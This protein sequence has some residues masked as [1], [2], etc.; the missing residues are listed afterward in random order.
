MTTGMSY[1]DAIALIKT[2]L[3]SSPPT[4]SFDHSKLSHKIF[5][6]ITHSRGDFSPD[7]KFKHK[8]TPITEARWYTKSNT[9][10]PLNSPPTWTLDN[11]LSTV[12]MLAF[13]IPE[14]GAGIAAAVGAF[15]EL[16]DN[17]GR[18]AAFQ[19]KLKEVSNE[20]K[21]EFVVLEDELKRFITQDKIREDLDTLEAY[22]LDLQNLM[23]NMLEKPS[24][25]TTARKGFSSK[26]LNRQHN[27]ATVL[28]R[29]GGLGIVWTM[30]GSKEFSRVTKQVS[31]LM[32]R[33]ESLNLT[34]PPTYANCSID[35][36]CKI[37][38]VAINA[39]ILY[40]LVNLMP[41][42][43]LWP[44]WDSDEFDLMEAVKS[45][46]WYSKDEGVEKSAQDCWIILYE[47]L[48]PDMAGSWL[49]RVDPNRGDALSSWMSIM[50]RID[51]IQINTQQP[52]IR[53]GFVFLENDKTT[54]FTVMATSI[55]HLDDEVIRNCS[56][57]QTEIKD[58]TVSAPN[59]DGFL[60]NYRGFHC[61]LTI[62][63]VMPSDAGNILCDIIFGYKA[64]AEGIRVADLNNNHHT[65]RTPYSKGNPG[66]HA[67]S[68]YDQILWGPHDAHICS[69]DHP[70]FME[71]QAGRSF[72]AWVA[73]VLTNYT[74]DYGFKIDPDLDTTTYD[75]AN[76]CYKSWLAV[77]GV[78]QKFIEAAPGKAK[79]TPL[80]EA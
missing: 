67:V 43:A 62:N 72:I 70:G 60:A 22:A 31:H 40:S 54:K 45:H 2:F 57:E 20:A 56:N 15:Q 9:A 47:K 76:I 14:A 3:K 61:T 78:A 11:T 59:Y 69:P 21:N 58:A 4:L 55:I 39:V 66:N 80:E 12:T 50:K 26:W 30:I 13:A 64:A 16:I 65:F 19:K 27:R 6:A 17:L 74:N 77:F 36:Y 41:I 18:Q 38:G 29:T 24:D 1:G 23:S 37:V 71:S 52:T 32:Q 48:N 63:W 68:G 28:S 35:A 34:Y 33:P 53:D 7:S 75:V 42:E 25:V 51:D 79:T 46:R 5:D 44:E 10:E 8:D 49:A 73:F